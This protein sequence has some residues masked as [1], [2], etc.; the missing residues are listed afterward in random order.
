MSMTVE[1]RDPV[2][3]GDEL[4]QPVAPDD[5]PTLRRA[6]RSRPR[7]AEHPAARRLARAPRGG[8]AHLARLDPRRHL[9]GHDRRRA[10]C[11][12]CSPR[13]PPAKWACAVFMLTSMLLFGNSALYHRFN[14][15]PKTKVVLKRIDHANI[16]LLIAGTY[17]PLAVLALPPDKGWLLLGDRLGRGAARHRLPRVLDQRAALALRGALPAARLGGGD[18][19]RRP[20]RRE[21]RDDG[22]RAS[23]AACSTRSAPIVYA[24]KKPNPW[25]GRL[26]IPRD[27]PRLHGARVHVPLDGDPDHRDGAR[28]PRWR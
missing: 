27:L 15:S 12:S 24:L 11:S 20:A 28:V 9:P 16:F 14:W 6:S 18:V 17:T 2:D 10:S 19:P 1:R 23:S 26:R 3:I 8:Q 25:P 13:A 7:P 21:R 22:A 5:P 4:S